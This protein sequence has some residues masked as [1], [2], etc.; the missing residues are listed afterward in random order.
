MELQMMQRRVQADSLLQRAKAIEQLI[1]K[2]AQPAGEKR[3]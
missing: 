1:E 3:Q 2:P